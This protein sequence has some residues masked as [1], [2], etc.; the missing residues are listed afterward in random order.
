MARFRAAICA[1]PAALRPPQTKNPRRFCPGAGCPP[2]TAGSVQEVALD[3]ENRTQDIL[4]RDVVG[5]GR[6]AGGVLLE[7]R[8]KRIQVGRTGKRR[9][10]MSPG[11][12]ETHV[13]I[14]H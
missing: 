11:E 14:R 3:A 13:E 12:I 4:V 2:A 6:P 5:A 10:Q 1:A 9:I 7:Y 8:T